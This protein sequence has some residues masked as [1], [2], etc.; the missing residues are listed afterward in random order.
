MPACFSI[1]KERA[2]VCSLL[3]LLNDIDTGAAPSGFNPDFFNFGHI[4]QA[5]E[6]GFHFL[7][8]TLF[9]HGTGTDSNVQKLRFT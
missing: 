2:L 4:F 6:K 9:R 8:H 7:G 3:L 1:D 5:A